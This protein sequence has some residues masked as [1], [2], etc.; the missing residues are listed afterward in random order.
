MFSIGREVSRPTPARVLIVGAGP[1]SLTAA[2]F[3]ARQNIDFDL[4]DARA[5]PVDES[6]ALGVHARSLEFMSMLGLD[7]AFIDQGHQTRYM[8]FHRGA[9]K[10]FKLDFGVLANDTRYPYMLVLPQSRSE[11]ILAGHLQQA[12]VTIG[13]QTRLRSFTQNE[14]GVE[15]EIEDVGGHVNRRRYSY[16][17]GCDGAGSLVR[18]ALDIAF[19]GETYPL[20]F[21]LSEVKVD[22]NAIDRNSSHVFMGRQSTV[23]V[24]P[25]PDDIYRI[26]GPD[27][28]TGEQPNEI[29]GKTDVEFDDFDRFLIRNDLLQHVRLHEPSRLVSYRIHKRV[30]ARYGQG[31]VFIAGDAAHIH[32][33]AGGQGMNTG[34]NDVA[35]L[36]WKIAAVLHGHA[37]ASLLDS[38]EAERRPAALSIVTNADAAMMKV[39][40]RNPGARI[41]FD[42]VAPLVTRFYQPHRL[43]ATLAQLSW[44]YP[45][46]ASGAD[47]KSSGDP[48]VG[49]RLADYPLRG[50]GYVNQ[51]LGTSQYVA[52]R[53]G[54]SVRDDSAGHDRDA[55]SGTAWRGAIASLAKPFTIGPGKMPFSGI[56]LARPDGYIA[57]TYPFGKE[58]DEVRMS[59]A[60]PHVSRL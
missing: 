33:P 41:L 12:G 14:E 36:T 45:P 3:L 9:K 43:L 40:S 5:A 23:A 38:Y 10:L 34:L 25:Q 35:N 53:S 28:S 17:I 47:D 13:W 49:T 20:R 46:S 22:R 30:A 48:A 55:L 59:R 54:E 52:F 16:L 26:V 44:R 21:L 58:L 31:R 15:A 11:R 37:D 29:A 4:I 39:V 32:S 60:M 50:G 57:A 18:N 6:R 27:F 56:V 8:T 2:A 24:I 42:Y 19:E 7:Q 1:T 51:R